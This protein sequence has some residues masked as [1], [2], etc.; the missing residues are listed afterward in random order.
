MKEYWFCLLR[1]W[2]RVDNVVFKTMDTRL[3]YRNGSSTIIKEFTVRE[4]EW[5]DVDKVAKGD[6]KIL[7]NPN[8]INDLLKI[9]EQ[10][11]T[12]IQLK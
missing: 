1:F 6:F 7:N 2:L 8:A 10:K 11:L 4:G 5:K 3:F 12:H 9:K